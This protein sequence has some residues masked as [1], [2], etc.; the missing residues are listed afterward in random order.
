LAATHPDPAGTGSG[1]LFL[2]R[3]RE[4]K[5]M[6]IIRNGPYEHV[7]ADL[8]RQRDEISTTIES[9]KRIRAFQL[10]ALSTSQNQEIAQPP[11]ITAVPNRNETGEF[12]GMS[13]ADAAIV[14]LAR[15]GAPMTNQE[16]VDALADGGLRSQSAQPL[17]TVGSIL[18][19]RAN[20][21]GDI[22]RVGRGTWGLQAWRDEARAI[23]DREIANDPAEYIGPEEPPE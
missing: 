8:E 15:R 4:E 21:V 1:W 18:N 9:L 22:V 10:G 12:A 5:Q 7:I 16:V 14:V 23:R 11:Q 2:N 13:V 17:N 6:A 20:D 19:R 3:I